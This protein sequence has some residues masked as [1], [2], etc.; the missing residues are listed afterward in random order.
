MHVVF[1]DAMIVSCIFSNFALVS[2][3]AA[4]RS[5]HGYLITDSSHHAL[6]P[7]LVAHHSCTTTTTTTTLHSPL[8]FTVA[9]ELREEPIPRASFVSRRIASPCLSPSPPHRSGNRTS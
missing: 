9:T 6:N 3:H 7:V 2:P 1:P 5:S 8:P 4:A